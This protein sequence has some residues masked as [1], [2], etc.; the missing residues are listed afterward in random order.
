MD[1]WNSVEPQNCSFADILSHHFSLPFY[2]FITPI[3]DKWHIP[4]Q[5]MHLNGLYFIFWCFLLFKWIFVAQLQNTCY[6]ATNCCF[7]SSSDG[8]TSFEE[9]MKEWVTLASL[10]WSTHGSHPIHLFEFDR[11]RCL[12]FRSKFGQRTWSENERLSIFF[13]VS[14]RELAT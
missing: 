9:R 4:S 7:R 2:K 6:S 5:R 1:V 10:E 13:D 12:C 11:K 3:N 14:N 8:L